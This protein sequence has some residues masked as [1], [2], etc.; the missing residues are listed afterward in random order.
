[1]RRAWSG[2]QAD[3]VADLTGATALTVDQMRT[4]RILERAREQLAQ[5]RLLPVPK[6]K[7]LRARHRARLAAKERYIRDLEEYLATL[8]AD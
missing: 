7:L 6:L 8:N 4:L 3:L 5:W 2:K 1:M